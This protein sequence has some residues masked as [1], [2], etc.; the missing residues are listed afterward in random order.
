MVGVVLCAGVIVTVVAWWRDR[1]VTHRHAVDLVTNHAE[2]LAAM[3]S[4]FRE[5]GVLTLARTPDGPL[6]NSRLVACGAGG[7]EIRHGWEVLQRTP[8]LDDALIRLDAKPKETEKLLGLMGELGIS[9]I[10]AVGP[11]KPSPPD[12][13]ELNFG[14]HLPVGLIYAPPSQTGL[15]DDFAHQAAH[16]ASYPYVEIEALSDSWFYFR[17][18][19]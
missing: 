14:S 10:D 6:V 18:G 11:P 16:G 13:F 8:D 7:C 15:R 19:V 9:A 4:T 5:A 2:Q 3:V 12:Y 1:V 17:G